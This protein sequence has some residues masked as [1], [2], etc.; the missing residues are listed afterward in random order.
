MPSIDTSLFKPELVFLSFEAKDR[1]DLFERLGVI[2]REKGY[3]TDNWLDAI[4]TRE[5]NYPT[6]LRC[7]AI[8]VAIPHTDPDTIV[9]PYIAILRP[10][11]PVEFRH[12][13]EMGDPVQAEM[14]VNLGL[15]AHDTDQVKVL[16]ALIGIFNDPLKVEI[17]RQVDSPLEMVDTMVEL[18][19]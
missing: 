5:Q 13:A 15:V 3:V 19:S 10:V 7:E 2:L 14:V 12:M 9:K 18:C 8:E 17:I 4:E 16:Q 1:Q 11:E 6:G